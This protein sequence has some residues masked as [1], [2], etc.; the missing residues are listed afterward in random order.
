MG[1]EPT[2]WEALEGLHRWEQH[3][4][5]GSSPR[6]RMALFLFLLKNDGRAISVGQLYKA[7]GMSGPTMR[8]VVDAF[9]D[10]GLATI[11]LDDKDSRLRLIR[12]TAMLERKLEEY[13]E[14]FMQVAW[15]VE[16]WPSSS[17]EQEK[18]PPVSPR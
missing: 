18:E 17:A 8:K 11:A 6:H 7:I 4:L 5:P 12:G 10:A 3:S 9:V 1:T 2:I 15:L 14:L 16:P 13:R